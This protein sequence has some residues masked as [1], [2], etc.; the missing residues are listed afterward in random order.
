MILRSVEVEN[1]LVIN[2]VKVEF[3]AGLT[4]ISGESGAGKSTIIDAICWCLGIENKRTK[5]VVGKVIVEFSGSEIVQI[6]RDGKN[7]KLNG[8]KISKKELLKKEFITICRQDHRLSFSTGS[9]FR[10][11]IDNL[12]DNKSDLDKLKIVY[13]NYKEIKN[14]IDGL[15]NAFN[16]D[17]E[18]IKNV[19]LEVES[20]NLQGNDEEKLVLQRREEIEVYKS[21]ESLVKVM[22]IL[23]GHGSISG[24]V[25]QVE[26]IGRY[27]NSNSPIISQIQQKV[28]NISSELHDVEATIYDIVSRSDSNEARLDVIDK[29]ICEI[30]DVAR[31]YRVAPNELQSLL[32]NYK[33]RL[34]LAENTEIKRS[35]LNEKL[36]VIEKE[37]STI[38]SRIN[39]LRQVVCDDLN[40]KMRAILDELMMADIDAKFDLCQSKLWNEF[41]NM[42]VKMSIG[43]RILSGGEMSR[44]LLAIKVATARLDI[45]IIF[46]EIDLGVGGAT[47]HKIGS[48]LRQL[49]ELGQV[50]VVSHQ[51][52]VA[53]HGIDHMLVS[54][55]ELFK[56]ER[57]SIDGRINEI[58]RM[59]SG[60]KTTPESLS[61]A[62]KLI[63]ECN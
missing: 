34:Y 11:V 63:E 22:Q 39:Q 14:E 58:A 49:G 55:D 44:L 28:E 62:K 48:K 57:L 36:R 35:E 43:R 15:K 38:C 1:F 27:L 26:N 20:L 50:I 10:D 9:D 29:R 31:K 19:V 56:I 37:F 41:G 33:K 52:Q 13:S 12:L 7:F 17:L 3:R 4:V 51:P 8:K 6:S 30:R 59:I 40:Y 61:A 18:Y 5:D 53:S 25:S 60:S 45:P 21:H 32:D 46:D 54:R 47:A 2:R 42:H 24:V 23:K 16:E